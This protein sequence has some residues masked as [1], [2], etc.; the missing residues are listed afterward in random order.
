MIK[1][2]YLTAMLSSLVILPWNHCQAVGKTDPKAVYRIVKTDDFE[3]TGDGNNDN[4]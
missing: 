4:Y 3:I 2:L 1:L